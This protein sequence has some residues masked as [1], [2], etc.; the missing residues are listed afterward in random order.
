[1]P[2]FAQ[3][4]EY[5][6][7]DI[8]IRNPDGGVPGWLR[9]RG[10]ACRQR[11]RCR[12]ADDPAIRDADAVVVRDRNLAEHPIVTVRF[13]WKPI[14]S[15]VLTQVAALDDLRELD[16]GR[17]SITDADVTNFWHACG[18]CASSL[19]VSE[20]SMITDAGVAMLAALPELEDLYVAGRG[21]TD[22]GLK[23]PSSLHKLRVLECLGC[24]SDGSGLAALKDLLNLQILDLSGV[25]G[26]HALSSRA[27][28]VLPA[29]RELDLG[30]NGEVSDADLK[31]IAE[32][33]R[34]EKY[35]AIL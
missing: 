32:L 16:F 5:N 17:L 30:C 26:R 6:N 4:D 18:T 15:A 23:S 10:T 24:R 8:A 29:L 33:P 13:D 11:R 28:R 34:L 2:P 19:R 7:C 12:G 25:R 9:G 1:M 21:I 3:F 31:L 35:R 14:S 27:L 20:A 22:I